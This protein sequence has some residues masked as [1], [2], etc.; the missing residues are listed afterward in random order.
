MSPL[1]ELRHSTAHVM[2]AAILRLFPDTLL[3]IGPPT[4]NGFYYDVTGSHRFSPED[5]PAIEETMRAIVAEDQQFIR[6]EIGREQALDYFQS[7]GQAFKVGRLADIPEGETITFFQNGEF[8]DLCAGTH[9]KSTGQIGAFKLQSIAG[10]Y[11]R[12]DE[13][14]PQLQRIYGTAFFHS[15]ELEDH[16]IKLEQAALR[17]HRKLGQ[18]LKLYRIDP[19]IGS[20]LPLLLP[21][22]A[23]IRNELEKLIAEKLFDYGYD[24]V[25]SPHIGSIDLYKTSGH[26]P[27]YA[28]SMYEPIHIDDRQFLLKPMN[29]PMHIQAYT[30]EPR[31]YRDLPQRYAEF[32]T[33]YRMEQ[34][35]ELSGLVRVRG[36]TQ[37]DGHI[38]CTADQ[39]KDEFKNCLSLVQEVMAVFDLKTKCRVS[40]RDPENRNKYAGGDELWNPAER[41]IIEVVKELGLEHTTGLGEAA[42]YGPK[43]DFMALDALGR[44]WQLGTIQVDFSLPERFSLE[45]TGKDNCPH[46]PVMIHRAVFGSIERFMG[47][48]IEHFAG[49]FPL[50]LAP[51]QIRILPI[52]DGQS[53]MAAELHSRCKK[54]RVRAAIDGSKDPIGA[55]IRRAQLDKTPLMLILGRREAEA[56]CVSVRSRSHGDE[57]FIGI[58]DFFTA[59]PTRLAR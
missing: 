9:L 6:K 33:V 37:D 19:T 58:N 51:E 25:H 49:D 15:S 45:Y 27:Y 10:S 20:G 29:C 48:L 5:F 7:R 22:G 3:D 55:K 40:L 56:G 43:L 54:L 34:S 36:F 50:W 13:T 47:L 31:S 23:I 41:C 1:E 52:S 32:G 26:Y 46:R 39:L 59:L 18:Q 38:F 44:S 12:G 4:A 14:Q 42:F 21:K 16:L 35:G 8:T 57:G 11:H 28:D 53:E 2:G 30:V 17:D 24:S